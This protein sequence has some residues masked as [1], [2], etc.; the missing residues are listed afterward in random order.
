MKKVLIM[1]FLLVLLFI[2]GCTQQV[3]VTF[4]SNGGTPIAS[5]KVTQG[6]PVKQPKN[7]IRGFDQFIGW[8]YNDEEWDFNKSVDEDMTLVAR[9]ADVGDF[10]VEFYDYDGNIIKT[11]YVDEGG[12][13]T[14]PTAPEVEG[15]VFSGW[16][17]DYENVTSNLEI[18]PIYKKGASQFEVVFLDYNGKKIVE[19]VVK[20]GESATAPA[21][22]SR[23]GY[24]FIGWSRT[25]DNVQANLVVRA[26]YVSKD[27]DYEISYEMNN[28]IWGFSTKNE[29]VENFLKDFYDF[30]KP[31]ESEQ[32]FIYGQGND[33]FFGTWK[34]Y[35]GGYVGTENKLLYENDINLDNEDYF[36]NS[37]KYKAKWNPLGAY[38]TTLKD[39]FNG[40]DYY[41]GTLDFYRY[42]INNPEQYI[43]IYGEEFYEFPKINEP[44]TTYKYSETNITLPRPLNSSFKGW[45]TNSD[46]TGEPVTEIKAYTLGEIELFACWDTAI[47]YEVSF[48]SDGAGDFDTIT[49]EYN[50][51]ITLPTGLTKEGYTFGGWYLNGVKLEEKLVFNYPYSLTI[52]AK[53]KKDSSTLEQL[54]YDGNVITYR[55]SS[56][57]VEIPTDYIQPEAQLR[58]TWV[59][60]YASTF[61]PSPI[62][63]TMKKNL[64]QVL[65]LL[66]EYNMN[67]MI[68]HIR[69]TNNAFYPTDL[70]P[71]NSSYGTKESFE[72][73]DYLEWLIDECHKRGIE[74]HAWLNPYR[75]RAN[76]YAA[77]T[78]SEIVAQ[79]YADY[80]LNPA[81]DPENILMTYSSNGTVGA[82]L[83]PY[84]EVVQD[85]IV[86]VCLEIME[87]YD[88][89]AIHFDD[90]FYAQM[91]SGIKVLEEPDQAEY[92]EFIL[93]NPNCGYSKYKADDKKQWRRD[94]IDKFIYK[95]HVAM[96]DFNK[97]HGR[98]VQLG[99]SPTGIYRNGDGSV[100][101]GSNTAGQEHYESYLFCDTMNWVRN[102]WIDYIMPQSYWAFTHRA[103]GYADVMDWWNE[104]VK[105]TNVNLYSGL[106]LYMSI[107]GGN[108]SWGTQPYEISNQVLYTT[109]LP[110]VK[111]V[112]IYSQLSLRQGNNSSSKLCY[113]GLM[114]LKNE[115]WTE[116]VPTP[117][118]MAHQYIR[119]TK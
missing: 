113:E 83:D 14:P 72:Q 53:W 9:Y 85:Y 17:T 4:D 28:G 13:A 70:A 63:A 3:V 6:S 40:T 57:A 59:T 110:N 102:E 55:N 20:Q 78:T 65:D 23:E 116:K 74:F 41:Y 90:Y 52:T 8:Y 60:S 99:I 46:F 39:R 19:Q 33:N 18:F 82:I 98:G 5:V 37:S 38:V 48:D 42:I 26:Q 100:K 84:K 114:R 93:N 103:A 80:P 101:S 45:Y 43:S 105:G 95:L 79:S 108:Y 7:P 92:E 106:G 104:A 51:E 97:E 87:K 62:E 118:T 21:D 96:T 68:F 86:D 12:N 117:K 30:V 91:S 94:N 50:Q 32:E 36:F 73:W 47:T 16:D 15:Y 10:R 111:G 31:T 67:C 81:S 58:A 71:I 77:S 88:V 69:T 29:M 27:K 22:P 49:V 44:F 61:S 76:G 25:F 2:V 75:I 119:D 112:S 54:K 34:N 109:K 24:I 66:D 11:E 56:V 1:A 35:I 89:D 107:D 115:Y 64:T